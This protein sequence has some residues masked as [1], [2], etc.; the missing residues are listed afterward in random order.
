MKLNEQRIARNPSQSVDFGFSLVVIS[1][2]GFR[3]DISCSQVIGYDNNNHH[4]QPH[5][6]ESE[7]KGLETT[8]TL[9]FEQRETKT[10]VIEEERGLRSELRDDTGLSEVLADEVERGDW[11][12]SENI[13]SPPWDDCGK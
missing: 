6:T 1:N 7:G 10:T 11:F 4:E 12:S 8:L 5:S 13:S 2:R 3:M 9:D